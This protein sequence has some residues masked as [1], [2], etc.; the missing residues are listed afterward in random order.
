[1]ATS[2]LVNESFDDFGKEMVSLPQISGNQAY[3]EDKLVVIAGFPA[4]LRRSESIAWQ[5]V[6]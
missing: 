1:M 2:R 4:A 6:T 3:F 5:A